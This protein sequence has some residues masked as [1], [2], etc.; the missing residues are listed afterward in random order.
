MSVKTC[1]SKA[2]CVMNC[3]VMRARVP[4]YL[5]TNPPGP[6]LPGFSTILF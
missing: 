2:E 6:R 1:V 4:V 5:E 3:C